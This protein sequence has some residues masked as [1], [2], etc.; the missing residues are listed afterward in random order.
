MRPR[1]ILVLVYDNE[2]TLSIRSLVLDTRG[3]HVVPFLSPLAALE[4]LERSGREQLFPHLLIA[5]LLLPGMDGNELVRRAKQLNP[6]LPAL[7]T[8][9]TVSA[10]DR[11]LAADAFLGKRAG[12]MVELLERVRILV[13]RKRGPKSK[14]KHAAQAAVKAMYDVKRGEGRAA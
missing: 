10:E 14:E 4:W 12:S 13:A 11:A 9:E 7:I 5:D 1:K 8:S 6:L 2:Q 3:Y